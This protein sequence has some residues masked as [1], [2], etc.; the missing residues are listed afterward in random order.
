[1][2]VLR[3][4]DKREIVDGNNMICRA[5]FT[6]SQNSLQHTTINRPPICPLL[7]V[8]YIL[9]NGDCGGYDKIIGTTVTMTSKKL[10]TATTTAAAF[11]HSRS[12]ISLQHTTIYRP[13]I[14]PLLVVGY[15]L[16]NGD[17]GGNDIIFEMSNDGIFL[18]GE[19]YSVIPLSF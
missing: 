15:I 14:G 12:Q 19:F 5:D 2:T 16:D 10:T 18:S 13:L 3:N 17:C 1:M 11:D 6:R 4:F 8:G 9:D 7:V